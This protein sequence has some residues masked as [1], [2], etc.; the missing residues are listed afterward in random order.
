[1]DGEY[2]VILNGE[3]IPHLRITNAYKDIRAQGNNGSEVKHYIRDKVRS[4]KFLNQ[5]MH[6]RQQTISN[7]AQQI[8]SRQRDFFEHGS[9]HLKP[10][11]MKEIADTV[12]VHET[13]VSRAVSGKYMATPWGVFE[14]KYFF[15]SG[16]QTA[17]GESL[18][19]I[20]V[21]EAILDL[22]KHENDSAPLSDHEIV[23]ILAERGIPIARRTVA[24]YRDE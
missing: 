5:S 10:M 2:Q 3:Q 4:G 23:E 7:I 11:T 1:M 12:G 8:V 22:V 20:S 16:Y 24:K 17:T 6:Q 9:S 21:K 13:T 14:M 19:N 15:T 18:S